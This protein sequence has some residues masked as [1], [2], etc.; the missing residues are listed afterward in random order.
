MLATWNR[1][2][3]RYG[4]A[5]ADETDVTRLLAAV[6]ADLARYA[7]R[8][9]GGV[10]CFEKASR[11]H[12]FSIRRSSTVYLWLP[13]YPVVAIAEAVEALYNDWSGATALAE[14]DDFT[15]DYGSGRL[16]RVG[17]W[18]SGHPSLRVTYTAG[19]TG[20]DVFDA[21][22]Y[23]PG[24]WASGTAY[25]EDDQV[26]YDSCVWTAAGDIASSTTPPPADPDNW[27]RTDVLLPG[28]VVEACLV[29]AGF[30]WQR[31][32]RLGRSGESSRGGSV[33][34]EARDELLPGVRTVMDRYR[35]LL[36]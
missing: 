32:S 5:D 26:L 24:A 16:T 29:Q 19:Y 28:D 34:H 10:P 6:S 7:G 18:L 2:Q 27:T 30:Q 35:R 3:T 23:V 17:A 11:V 1:F 4:V 21:E 15:L 9:S 13:A 12:A 22:G 14:D 36:A 31:R 33:S 8:V 25:D 20:P